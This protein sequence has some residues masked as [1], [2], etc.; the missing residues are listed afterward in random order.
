MKSWLSI[1]RRSGEV[2]AQRSTQV[3]ALLPLVVMTKAFEHTEPVI[4][5]LVLPQ[6]CPIRI[7]SKTILLGGKVSLAMNINVYIR[8]SKLNKLWV[9][10]ECSSNPTSSGWGSNEHM[11]CLVPVSGVCGTNLLG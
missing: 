2:S 9:L 5:H 7:W 1:L 8:R 10:N 4:R 11:T 3:D 6:T